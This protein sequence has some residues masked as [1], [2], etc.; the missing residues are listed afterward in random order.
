MRSN[1]FYNKFN[2]NIE[3]MNLEQLKDIIMNVIRKIPE[4]KYEEILDIFNKNIDIVSENE[5]KEKIEEYD[6]KFKQIDDFELY[7]HATGY[8]DYGEYYNPWGGDW[9][10]EYTDDDDKEF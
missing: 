10:W 3:G 1:E 6:K 7:F 4:T 5:I 9:V 8:E 2:K